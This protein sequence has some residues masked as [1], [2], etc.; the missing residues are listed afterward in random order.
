[1][2]MIRRNRAVLCGIVF[3]KRLRKR[4]ELYELTAWVSMMSLSANEAWG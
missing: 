2:L 4:D 1:M 3:L